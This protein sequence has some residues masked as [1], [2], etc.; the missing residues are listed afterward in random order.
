MQATYLVGGTTITRH[1]ECPTCK[2]PWK[3]HDEVTI[4]MDGATRPAL[5]CR[6][7]GAS[8]V[9]RNYVRCGNCKR[10]HGGAGMVRRCYAGETV[11]STGT[12]PS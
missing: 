5:Q 3:E 7:E 11:M 2:T 9:K 8:K 6:E 12:R 10:Y 4:P 1:V